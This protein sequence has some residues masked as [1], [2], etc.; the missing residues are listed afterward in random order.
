MG[1]CWIIQ[2]TPPRRSAVVASNII[3][4]NRI[5]LPAQRNA[6]EAFTINQLAGVIGLKAKRRPFGRLFFFFVIELT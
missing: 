2:G 1:N 5:Y 6:K 3:I 4:C